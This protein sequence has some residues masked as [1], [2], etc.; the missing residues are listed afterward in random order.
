MQARYHAT[1]PGRFITWRS[2]VGIVASEWPGSHFKRTKR[3]ATQ[4]A[5]DP[6]A[7]WREQIP[8]PLRGIRDDGFCERTVLWFLEGDVRRTP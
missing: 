4:A 2:I 7:R 1:T 5:S 3:D 6:E 8:H